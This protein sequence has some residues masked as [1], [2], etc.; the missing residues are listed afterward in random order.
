MQ[1]LE[2]LLAGL[3]MQLIQ[4]SL[5]LPGTLTNAY[6][7]YREKG[8]R[9]G[10]EDILETLEEVSKSFGTVYLVIDALDECLEEVR[11]PLILHLKALSPS[12]RL[13]LTTRPIDGIL[14]E[15][16]N[17][18]T[19]EISANSEDLRRYIGS[20]IEGNSRLARQLQGKTALAHEICDGIIAKADGMYASSFQLVLVNR[21][22][23]TS[24]VVFAL[25]PL[26]WSAPTPFY[27]RSLALHRWRGW[28]DIALD[29]LIAR[30]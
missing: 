17:E 23:L 20:R 3:C 26:L 12:I 13:L 15:F 6:C 21:H 22:F 8:T 11:S 10:R 14:S 28:F 5:P 25:H 7:T 2:N 18:T 19:L 24:S 29:V 16:R 30:C 27:N 4:A 1:T 9:L